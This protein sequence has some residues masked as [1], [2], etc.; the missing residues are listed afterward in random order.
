MIEMQQIGSPSKF[1]IPITVKGFYF[2]LPFICAIQCFP[3]ISFSTTIW[4]SPVMSRFPPTFS[5]RS[6]VSGR[7]NYYL[8]YSQNEYDSNS[9]Q[10]LSLSCRYGSSNIIMTFPPI[11]DFPI[12]SHMSKNTPYFHQLVLSS[13]NLWGLMWFNMC[14]FHF[15]KPDQYPFP[16]IALPSYLVRPQHWPLNEFNFNWYYVFEIRSFINWILGGSYR[17]GL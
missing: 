15:I 16:T 4:P 14:P 9:T 8:I 2:L 12:E 6:T 17:L 3:K 5:P 10:L 13:P 11:N 1:L 7:K